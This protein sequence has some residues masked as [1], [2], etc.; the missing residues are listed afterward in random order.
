M[1][2]AAMQAMTLWEV[3]WAEEFHNHMD[4]WMPAKSTVRLADSMVSTTAVSRN[5]VQSSLHLV[6]H[7][8]VCRETP[9]I[10]VHG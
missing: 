8:V 5:I 10:A 7:P 9:D 3:L 6:H 2:V 1:A 4:N